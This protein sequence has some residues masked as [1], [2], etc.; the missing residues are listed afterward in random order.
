MA[1]QPRR[2][3]MFGR[4]GPLNAA[5]A[6]AKLAVAIIAS[7]VLVALVPTLGVWL[8]LVPEAVVTR[9]ALWQPLTYIPVALHPFGVL[10]GALIVWS[11]GGSLEQSWG[12]R[13][14]LSFALGATAVSGLLTAALALVWPG[15]RGQ[16]Y[17]GATVMLTAVW[18]AYGWSFGQARLQMMLVGAV[19][20]N[21]FALFGI[22]LVG[23]KAAFARSLVPVMPELFAIGCAYV[24]VKV[25]TPRVLVLKVQRWKM[26]RELK[27]RSRRLR[28]V[29]DDRN[30][31]K[32]S[33]R[34]IH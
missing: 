32:G 1:I 27:S 26:A 14:F 30:T 15:L 8:V 2:K 22:L 13:R 25:G 18:L 17:E 5:S 31:D 21:T 12:S 29:S 11:I 16:P 4:G 23:I 34:F 3:S 10:I 28:V 9:F 33:D 7:S 24:Y 20:G 6:A 19:S